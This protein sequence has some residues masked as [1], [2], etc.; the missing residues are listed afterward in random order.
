MCEEDH[1]PL[2]EAAN[3]KSQLMQFESLI[4]T[5]P[6]GHHHSQTSDLRG[7]KLIQ[8]PKSSLQSDKQFL[9]LDHFLNQP[10]IITT[11]K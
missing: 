8:K 1:P 6:Q 4:E 10:Q 5:R 9:G 3:H 11:K 7:L 2:S